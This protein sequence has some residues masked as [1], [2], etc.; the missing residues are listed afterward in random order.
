MKELSIQFTDVTANVIGEHGISQEDF[1]SVQPEIDRAKKKMETEDLYF[2]KLPYQDISD[3]LAYGKY[4]REHF[5]NF[6]LIGIGGSALGPKALFKSTCHTFHNDLPKEKRN[7]PRCYFEDNVDPDRMYDLL[8][9]LDLTKT[10]INIISKSGRTIE[11][12]SQAMILIDRL[13]KEMPEDWAK[14]IVI[15]TDQDAG[16]LLQIAK[17]YQIKTFYIPKEVGGRFSIFSPVGILSG[18]VCGCDIEAMLRGARDMDERCKTPNIYQ[19]HAYLYAVL[20]YILMTKKNKNICVMMPYADCLKFVSDWFSQLWAESLGKKLDAEGNVVNVGQTPVRAL[21]SVDQHSQLQLYAEGPYDKVVTFIRVN[22]FHHKVNITNP[23]PEEEELKFL[24]G[25]SLNKLINSELAAI[26]YS[27]TQVKRP[28]IIIDLPDCSEYYLGQLFMMLE[29][30]TVFAGYMLNIN[31]FDQ[32]GVEHG[33]VSIYALM[34][35]EGY[36]DRAAQLKKRDETE[37]RL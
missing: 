11:T 28:S 9:N 23:F 3:I 5:D 8:E 37:F 14:N 34:G 1:A 30:A 13:K 18:A 32:P 22:A 21:G 29:I 6:L 27:L 35:K 24:D 10:C 26:S 16:L 12:L 17:R 20:Q 19:N 4:I 33:K 31:P 7:A 2:R 36:E 25:S 15:T